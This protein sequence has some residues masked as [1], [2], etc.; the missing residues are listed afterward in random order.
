MTS[1]Y[2]ARVQFFLEETEEELFHEL[3]GVEYVIRINDIIYLNDV[4]Y[5]VE[6]ITIYLYDNNYTNPISGVDEWAMKEEFYKVTLSA[7]P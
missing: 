4:G 3:R 6:S 5:K 1:P 2:R 7:L